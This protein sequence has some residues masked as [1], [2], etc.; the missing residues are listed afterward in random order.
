MNNPLFD[1]GKCILN[2]TSK[3]SEE[4]EGAGRVYMQTK[5]NILHSYTLEAGYN[6]C[7]SINKLVK[8][9]GG[10]AAEAFFTT[11]GAYMKNSVC[12]DLLNKLENYKLIETHKST[13][14][15]TQRDFECMGK[16]I[17]PS[18]LDLIDRNP[19][20]RVYNTPL[21]S[22]RS[23]KLY[24]AY[25]IFKTKPYSF[26]PYL[27]GLLSS[28][29]VGLYV[30]YV[31]DQFIDKQVA[32][33]QLANAL[34]E[35]LEEK[36]VKKVKKVKK[37][38]NNEWTVD[39]LYVTVDEQ[40]KKKQITKLRESANNIDSTLKNAKKLQPVRAEKYR[41]NSV[42]HHSTVPDPRKALKDQTHDQT[43]EV[44]VNRKK[45]EGSKIPNRYQS[46]SMQRI[47]VKSS[48][49]IVRNTQTTNTALFSISNK[50]KKII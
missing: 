37:K 34:M 26:N 14:F 4:K 21:S 17:L 43:Y 29:N 39:V 28:G 25:K 18:L 32:D 5:F 13:Y 38:K 24:L 9:S 1:Y 6:I 41:S 48:I 2:N 7:T 10:T 30:R 50:P 8:P 20:N 22:M 44:Q 45:G 49:G 16:D 15:M 19:F 11:S 40:T 12:E 3:S 31:E 35:N 27:G 23:L 36:E 33:E 46:T 47:D 42:K